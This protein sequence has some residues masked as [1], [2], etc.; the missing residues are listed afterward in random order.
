MISSP[1]RLPQIRKLSQTPYRRNFP[2]EARLA[3]PSRDRRQ[4]RPHHNE[5]VVSGTEVV[6]ALIDSTARFAD[7]SARVIA[8]VVNRLVKTGA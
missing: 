2:N 7:G 5:P 6:A 8:S 3:D 1:D 4:S